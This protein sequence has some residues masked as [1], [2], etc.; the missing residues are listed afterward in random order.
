[1]LPAFATGEH[2]E[3]ILVNP[4]NVGI[5]SD[6]SDLPLENRRLARFLY[7]SERTNYTAWT[8]EHMDRMIRELA[9]FRPVILEANPSLLARLCRYISASGQTVFQPGLIV[10]TYENP[11]NLH[12]PA[13]PQSFYLSD[14]QFL[15]HPPKRVMSSCSAKPVNSTR[16]R[17]F[18][19]WI[20]SR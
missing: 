7:L 16:T 5:A 18:A 9:V 17:S 6:N 19:V 20:S 8:A 15:R 12:Y 2:P 10:L 14:R 13:N 3:A 11:T 1:M 4:L